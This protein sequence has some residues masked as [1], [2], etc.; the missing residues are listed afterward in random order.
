MGSRGHVSPFF[1]AS[2]ILVLKGS[3][4]TVRKDSGFGTAMFSL[5]HPVVPQDQEFNEKSNIPA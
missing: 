4:S 5:Y 2:A 1:S 3:T